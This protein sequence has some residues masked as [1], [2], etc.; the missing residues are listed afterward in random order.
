MSVYEIV[1][2]NLC[3]LGIMMKVVVSLDS[4]NVKNVKLGGIVVPL[5]LQPF[6]TF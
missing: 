3:V 4:A 5:D 6:V 1:S 2:V